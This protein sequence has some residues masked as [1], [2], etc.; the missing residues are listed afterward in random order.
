MSAAQFFKLYASTALVFLAADLLWLGTVGG[1]FYQAQLGHLLAP[2]VRWVAAVLFYLLFVAGLLVFATLPALAAGSL[3]RA[4]LLGAF[5]GLLT[6]ATFD[7]TC[8]ALF[9]DFPVVVAVVDLAWG[10][11]LSAGTASAAWAIGHHA[12]GMG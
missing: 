1:R 7:L 3:A 8:L 2:E 6:Y 11:A 10:T 5:L 4:A 12:L 9:R